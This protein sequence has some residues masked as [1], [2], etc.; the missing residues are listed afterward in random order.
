MCLYLQ[1]ADSGSAIPDNERP[2]QTAALCGKEVFAYFKWVTDIDDDTLP[3]YV[4]S[5]HQP[6]DFIKAIAPLLSLSIHNTDLTYIL[7]AI[8]AI[9][10]NGQENTPIEIQRAVI[11][12]TKLNASRKKKEICSTKSKSYE[13]ETNAQS[14]KDWRRPLPQGWAQPKL[15][16]VHIDQLIGAVEH[17]GEFYDMPLDIEKTFLEKVK[18]DIEGELKNIED[19]INAPKTHAQPPVNTPLSFEV[20]QERF[21]AYYTHVI[22]FARNFNEEM[23]T[24][25]WSFEKKTDTQLKRMLDACLDAMEY[26]DI[27][28]EKLRELL[29]PKEFQSFPDASVNLL[30]APRKKPVSTKPVVTS[31]PPL[32]DLV[33]PGKVTIGSNPGLKRYRRWFQRFVVAASMIVNRKSLPLV[34]QIVE[35]NL[36]NNGSN[37]DLDLSNKM[38][39][40]YMTTIKRYFF[41]EIT[42]DFTLPSVTSDPSFWVPVWHSNLS[43]TAFE[44][45]HRTDV[46]YQIDDIVRPY[47]PRFRSSVKPP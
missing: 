31:T 15:M 7:K 23:L 19:F 22:N 30:P 38:L 11:E 42:P 12:L 14:I 47:I 13:N 29:E 40:S 21:A 8:K 26:N 28:H 20:L 10:A 25:G 36:S 3:V 5:N 43:M 45:K 9:G 2:L 33:K 18:T 1:L 24:E 35:F 37:E 16:T 6:D 34:H 32:E 27:I 44:S 4:A 41:P 17:I 39:E 46:T